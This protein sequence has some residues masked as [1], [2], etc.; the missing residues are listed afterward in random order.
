MTRNVVTVTPDTEVAEAARL[1]LEK[2]LNG[3]PVM[4]GD[5]LVGIICQSDLIAEQKKLPIPSFFTILDTFVPLSSPGRTEREVQ[6]ITAVRVAD[7][8]TLHP[9]TVDP[10]TGI[11]EIASLMVGKNIHTIPVMLKD[12]LVGVVGK[13]DILRTL[14]PSQ[15]K[16]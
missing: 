3:V 11:D 5:N 14:V 1:L 10:E 16:E 7:A 13:E 9:I 4:E 15:N 8:M 2:H 12:K 6:K